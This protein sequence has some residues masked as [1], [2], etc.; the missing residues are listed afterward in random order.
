M[1]LNGGGG[2][3][4][5]ALISAVPSGILNAHMGSL[6]GYR[7]MNVLEWSLFYRQQAGVTL[8][9]IE[10]GIDTGDIIQFRE[11]P[12]TQGDMIADL[13]EKSLIVNLELMREMIPMIEAGTVDRNKQSAHSGKQYYVMHPRLKRMVENS[14]MIQDH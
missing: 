12:R 13:R 8:H 4:R 1:L 11:V 3:F 2:I 5:D 9:F 10:R 6:P 14:L 7:G